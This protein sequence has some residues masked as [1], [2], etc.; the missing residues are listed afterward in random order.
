M[1]QS[2][3]SPQRKVYVGTF[4]HSVSLANLEILENAAIGIE[5]NGIIAFVE[6]DMK[7]LGL[8]EVVGQKYGWKEPHIVKGDGRSMS[9]FFPG[10]VDTH[11]HACQF[12]NAGIFGKS[13]LLDWLL[14]YTFPLEASFSSVPK[15]SRIYTHCI[16][17]TLAHGTTTATYFATKHV[18]ATNLLATLCHYLGQRAFIGRCN[19]DSHTQ[20]DYYKDASTASAIEDTKATIAHCNNLDPTRRLV[21]PIL[22]PRFGP[23]CTSDLFSALGALHKETKLPIQTHISENVS[24]LALVHK[25]FPDHASYAAVYDA[26]NLLTPV[27]VLAHGIH[28]SP[29]ERSLVKSRGASVSHCPI[30]NSYLGS[31]ICPVRELLDAG[32][33]VS[34]GTDVSGGWSP[35]ILHAAREAGGVSRLRTA[36]CPPDTKDEDK[37]R[38]K[39]GVEEVLWMAT[40]GG[41]KALGLEERVGGFEVGM[42]WDAQFVDLGAEVGE[43]G[44][45]GRGGVALWGGEG[46]EERMAKWVF[47]GDERNTQAVW[48]GGRLVSGGMEGAEE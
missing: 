15:A 42:E 46:W 7:E 25:L 44:A 30:S 28:L 4:I 27:T 43:D 9:F 16:T 34:L 12:P 38:L 14:T 22:T 11:I 40:R 24:E 35:S 39:L 26:Y 45:G 19:M 17:R 31:G 3:Q 10:F 47:C 6:K 29:E 33:T 13:T 5:E 23:S 18:P 21:C 36:F 20:P 37:E 2:K 1:A 32:I 8:A 48:V 41:A